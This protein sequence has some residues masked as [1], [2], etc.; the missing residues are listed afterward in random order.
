VQRHSN[1]L[2]LK[3]EK[4]AVR[5]ENTSFQREK[6]KEKNNNMLSL[7]TTLLERDARLEKVSS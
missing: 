6:R 4:K 3:Q 2:L 7:E 1:I 5:L